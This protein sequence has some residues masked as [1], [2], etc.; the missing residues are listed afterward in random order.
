MQ[1]LKEVATIMIDDPRVTEIVML[2]VSSVEKLAILHETVDLSGEQLKEIQQRSTTQ[3]MIAKKNR[4]LN[5]VW[6]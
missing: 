2:S 5:H 6:L 3:K 1:E 4:L